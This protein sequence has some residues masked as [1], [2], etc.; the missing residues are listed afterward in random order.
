MAKQNRRTRATYQEELSS[1]IQVLR[2]SKDKK[3]PVI[4]EERRSSDT[5]VVT[6]SFVGPRF[7]TGHVSCMIGDEPTQAPYTI[8]YT[9]LITGDIRLKGVNV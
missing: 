3:V 9:D 1:I 4:V 5:N 2:K 6:V 8:S 7:A